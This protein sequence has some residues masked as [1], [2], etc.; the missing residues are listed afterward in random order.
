L[1]IWSCPVTRDERIRAY[2]TGRWREAL[3]SLP[4]WEDVLLAAL[5]RYK[6]NPDAVCKNDGEKGT[7]D[8]Q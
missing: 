1:A 3:A 2:Q 6:G 7:E 8:V 4:G 5:S